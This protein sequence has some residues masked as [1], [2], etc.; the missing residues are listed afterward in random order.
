MKNTVILILTL[1]LF[2]CG[3]DHTDFSGDWIEKK[4]EKDRILIKKNADN[5]IVE[6]KNRKFPAQLKDGLLEISDEIPIKA[7]IDEN[8]NLIINGY[9]YIRF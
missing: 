7:T 2:S 4:E 9:E 8:D 3:V 5:Y 6:N 1:T